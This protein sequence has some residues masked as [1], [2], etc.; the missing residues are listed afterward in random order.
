[1]KLNTI[2]NRYIFTE[3]FPVFFVSV[4]FFLFLFLM[5]RMLYIV[6]LILNYDLSLAAVLS[7][8]V[9][10][11]PSFL[12]YVLPLSVMMSVLL[13]TLRLSGDNE[14]LAFKTSGLSLYQLLPPVIAFCLLGLIVTMFMTIAV[15]PKTQG[16][17]LSTM[18]K[19][20]ADNINIGLKEQAFNAGIKDVV[21]YAGEIDPHTGSMRNI[22]IEDKSNPE[23]SVTL[24]APRGFIV[25][26]AAAKMVSLVLL[27]GEALRTNV[28]SKTSNDMKFTRFE[29]HYDLKE[30]L[31]ALDSAD[32]QKSRKEMSLQELRK[33]IEL[34]AD[35]KNNTYYRARTALA[36]RFSMPF[37]CLFIGVLAFALGAQLHVNRKSFGLLLGFVFFLVYYILYSMGH[38]MAKKG[39]IDPWLGS[40][41]PNIVIG[42][43][44]VYF[45]VQVAREK[46]LWINKMLLKLNAYM[47]SFGK[48]A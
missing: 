41:M 6:N 26:D 28:K 30:L 18:A 13:T 47:A 4:I 10:T 23:M 42:I 7:I 29:V 33:T 11:L 19:Q 22:F 43:L 5:A 25:T 45:L 14:I 3:M 2:I 37:A 16:M 46:E 40:W 39:Q 38:S 44:A 1:M 9:L 48:Q 12:T 36:D 24:T 32:R 20:M 34:T 35:L 31:G 8:V 27:D 17:L 15:I 21:I